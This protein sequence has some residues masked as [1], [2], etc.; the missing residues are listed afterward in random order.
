MVLPVRG[1]FAG[2][3]QEW[4][5][6]SGDESIVTAEISGETVS[7]SPVSIGQT[8]VTVEAIRGDL[9][10]KQ[11]FAVLVRPSPAVSIPDAT[12]RTAIRLSLELDDGDPLTEQKMRQLTYLNFEFFAFAAVKDITGLEH[13]VNLTSLYIRKHGRIQHQIVDISPVKNLT[14]LTGLFLGCESNQ[15]T[16]LLLEN[17]TNLFT[18]RSESNR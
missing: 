11:S 6:S 5:I 1:Y 18:A 4:T 10:A 3:V 2:E 9:R 8:T 12:L 17:L 16:S 15:L 7:L 13:A 14:K